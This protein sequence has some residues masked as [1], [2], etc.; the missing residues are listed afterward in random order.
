M[1]FAIVE[2]KI[3][4]SRWKIFLQLKMQF[5]CCSH[6]Y[7]S[8]A[9]ESFQKFEK[10]K[11]MKPIREDR[12]VHLLKPFRF[13]FCIIVAA[14]WWRCVLCAMIVPSTVVLCCC[15]MLCIF[16]CCVLCL[17]AC[18]DVMT[19]G[20]CEIKTYPTGD[21]EMKCP[22]AVWL[23]FLLARFYSELLVK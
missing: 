4:K 2:T 17:I 13:I 11:E 12:W 20:L 15:I 22:V 19:V 23:F 9:S 1:D 18:C 14:A 3:S 8:S 16:G 6:N 21:S 10:G 5:V 7:A